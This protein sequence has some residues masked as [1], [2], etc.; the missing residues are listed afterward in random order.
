VKKQSGIYVII[1]PTNKVYIGLSSNLKYRLSSYKNGWEKSDRPIIHS[2]KKHG[3]E[4]HIFEV[5]E[6]CDLDFLS[7]R[8]VYWAGYYK[9]LGFK[10]LNAASCG[11]VSFGRVVSQETR[12]R[13]SNTMSG[14]RNHRY[15][16]KNN[17]HQR[18]QISERLTGHEVSQETKRK[19]SKSNTGKIR[20]LEARELNSFLRSGE[21][22]VSAKLNTAQVKIIVTLLGV[23]SHGDIARVFNVSKS[24]IA[25]ISAGRKWN[26]VTGFPKRRKD[27]SIPPPLPKYSTRE[28]V[29]GRPP[30]EHPM[31][32]RKRPDLAE[33]NRQRGKQIRA[34]KSATV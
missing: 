19:I 5:I 25:G 3:A 27:S 7:E 1:S 11:G 24:V 9:S 34:A 23:I 33:R 4:N 13:M 17:E 20:S 2:L 6:Y 18:K 29:Y 12:E 14:S 21:K 8:E 15:G 30:E 10:M 31:F 28:Y 32:G 22:S 16:K 26:S